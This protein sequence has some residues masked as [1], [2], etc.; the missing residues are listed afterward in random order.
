MSARFKAV[1][2]ACVV[3]T[4]AVLASAGSLGGKVKA[5]GPGT[6]IVYIEPASGISEVHVA[7]RE[8][9]ITQKSMEFEPKIIAVPVGGTVTFRNDDSPAHNIYWPSVGGDKKLWH[10]LGT[11]NSGQQRTFK[12]EHPGIVPLLCNVHPEMEGYV[13]V[14]ATP[15]YATTDPTL[16][17]Y[18]IPNIPN[19]QYKV[20]AWHAGKKPETKVV[21]VTG[22]MM[23]D[24]DLSR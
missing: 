2:T 19:G 20:T 23:L 4:C 8:Y 12:F 22:S 6:T 5:N 13:I 10:N 18:Q 17:M 21:S 9:V 7:Q 14:S 15:Y 16:G 3:F 24:F 11:F 1:L